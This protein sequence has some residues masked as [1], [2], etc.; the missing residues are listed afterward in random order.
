MA[1]T[2]P[3]AKPYLPDAKVWEYAAAASGAL[4]VLLI[5][6]TVHR[7]RPTPGDDAAA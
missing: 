4:L 1:Y 5:G 6:K 7:A 2:D 3:A